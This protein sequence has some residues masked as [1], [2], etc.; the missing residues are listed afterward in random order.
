MMNMRMKRSWAMLALALLL[1][2]ALFAP[3]AAQGALPEGVKALCAKA[4]PAYTVAKWD[5]WGDETQ[6]QYALALTRGEENI[7]CIAEKAPG[8]AAYA[9]TVQNPKALRQGEQLP[10]LYIDTGGDSLFYSYWDYDMYKT[11]YHALKQN[12]AWGQVSMNYLDTGYEHYDV[13]IWV[14]I[15]GDH[16]VYEVGRYDKLE[17]RMEDDSDNYAPL[18]VSQAFIDGLDLAVFDLVMLSPEPTLITPYPGL[19]APLMEEGDVLRQVLVQSQTL[20]LLVEKKDGTLRLRIAEK[21]GDG[22]AVA[23]TGSLPQGSHM[24]TWHGS[25]RRTIHLYTDEDVLYNFSKAGDGK[26]YL[27]SVQGRE[28]F[29]LE[30][31]A[32]RSWEAGG[33]RRNDGALYGQAPWNADITRLDLTSLPATCEE[34]AA[35]MDT[36]MYALVANPNPGDRLHLRTKPNKGAAS[37]GKFYNRTP[38]YV[39]GV[40]GE[41]AH[42]RI[43]NETNGLEGYMMKKYLAFGS[44]KAS[45]ACAFPQL[46]IKEELD[47]EIGVARTLASAPFRTIARSG[48]WYIV[49][50][51]EDGYVILTADGDVGY[52]LQRMFYEGNG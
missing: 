13:D 44:D 38:V 10:Q 28:T 41:W 35:Q 45:I 3:A 27:S 36:G 16:L 30:Y 6:G 51:Y 1:C 21:A 37:L 39:L 8:E 19:C 34:A 42:V 18:P 4:Y 20:V 14:G 5:G 24:D 11:T 26:W 17:N 32:L 23:Q 15:S 40:E 29:S 12:G 9:F 31:N 47:D 33:I 48:D 50:V 22:Y 49:G 2:L 25:A 7:L 43:G 52:V 46:F